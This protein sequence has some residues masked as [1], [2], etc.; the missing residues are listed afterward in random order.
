MSN[1]ASDVMRLAHAEAVALGHAV[2]GTEHMLLGL[3]AAPDEPAARALAER[4][5]YVGTLRTQVRRLTAPGPS[6]APAGRLPHSP[7]AKQVVERAVWEARMREQNFV[8]PT[9]LMIALLA[10]EDSVAAD[11]LRALGVDP[12][13]LRA[14]VLREVGWPDTD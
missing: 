14:D 6:E 5:V 1:P 3:T 9:H 12:E 11:V 4:G 7:L 2:I 10:V 8:G 13:E